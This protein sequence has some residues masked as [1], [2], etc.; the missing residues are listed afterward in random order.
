M[1]QSLR[2]EV[3]PHE[4][5]AALVVGLIMLLLLTIIGL[6]AMQGTT[7]Q[8][9]M[10][11]NMRDSTMALQAAE[12]ALRYVEQDFLSE[13]NNLD[14]G[15][16][17][18]NCSGNCQI[19]NSDGNNDAT[20]AFNTNMS[21]WVAEATNYGSFTHPQSGAALARPAGSTVT[22]PPLLLVEYVHYRRDSLDTGGGSVSDTGETL[23]RNTAIASGG[24]TNSQAVA[25]TMFAR[26][27]K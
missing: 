10:S 22:T 14:V 20:T 27:F 24:T 12:V 11:G 17:F 26:R 23:Y 6:S 3:Y 19:V 4:T 18:A 16:D 21:A 2:T 15:G 7:L 9:K 1:K 8:E 25:Q 5:G 13:L